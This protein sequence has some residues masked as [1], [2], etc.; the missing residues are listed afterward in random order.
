M[1]RST[2]LILLIIMGMVALL[3]AASALGADKVVLKIATISP[4]GTVLMD[5]FK[6]A[7]KEIEE[8]TEGRV[9]MKF[10]PGG[11][12]GNDTVILRKMRTG[13]IHGSTF[14]AGGM[15]EVYSNY[16]IM[17]LP[18]LFRDYKEVDAVRKQIG[19]SLTKALEEHGY[20]SLGI[21]EA[22]FVYMMSSKPLGGPE[23]LKGRKIWIPE[24]D[25]VGR[26]V[27]ETAGVPPVPLPLP[28][29]L[30]GLQTGLLDTVSSSPV[31]T[32][33]LQ[34]F[35]KVK[36]LTE[37]PLIYSYGTFA[38]TQKAWNKVPEADRSVVR[39][40]LT[41]ELTNVD[42]QNRKDNE[43]ALQTLKK[44]G[45]IFVPLKPGST[46]QMQQIADDAIEKLIEQNL[47][48]PAMLATI[49]AIVKTTRQEP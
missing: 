36:Y 39:D 32:V 48:D 13:Q 30:T 17:S 6:T 35:T 25:P 37:H 38:F 10:Y 18:L 31:G 20:V 21:F 26:A 5:A 42:V 29:V 11:V 23:D 44:Q 34:W 15:S 12:M 3:G 24:G 4:D 40:V 28:D 8:K 9:Q 14:T 45:L 19:P 47:F 27:F 22:G 16:Q 43:A 41:R 7:S 2:R 46:Q 33:V 49:R 1:R